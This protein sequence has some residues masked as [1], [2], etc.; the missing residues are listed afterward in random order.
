MRVPRAGVPP[1]SSS[2]QCCMFAKMR[3]L[4]DSQLAKL[5][6]LVVKIQVFLG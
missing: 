4:L 6:S 5:A 1:G 3:H 2:N